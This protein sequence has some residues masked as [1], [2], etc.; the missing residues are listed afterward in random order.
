M[1]RN[2]L[3]LVT[4]VISLRQSQSALKIKPDFYFPFKQL[5]VQAA[6]PEDILIGKNVFFL[7]FFFSGSWSSNMNV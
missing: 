3:C 2:D 6:F 7:H 5:T 4:L 1:E